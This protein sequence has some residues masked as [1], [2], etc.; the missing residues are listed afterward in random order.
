[1]TVHEE[2]FEELEESELYLANLGLPRQGYDLMRFVRTAETYFNNSAHASY[3]DEFYT[4]ANSYLGG[5]VL[6]G[7]MAN[8]IEELMASIS[9]VGT[10]KR[11]S[12]I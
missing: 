2:T 7:D 5:T 6:L 12:S 10:E 8:L 3:S 9:S 1:M 11:V 4:F